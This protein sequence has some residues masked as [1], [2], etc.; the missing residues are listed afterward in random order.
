[1]RFEESSF[2]ERKSENY[3]GLNVTAQN[4]RKKAA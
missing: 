1:M 3:M 4:L 2:M